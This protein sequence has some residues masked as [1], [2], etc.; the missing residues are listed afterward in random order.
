MSEQKT[1]PSEA[2]PGRAK[3][4]QTACG[5][6]SFPTM[7]YTTAMRGCQVASLLGA[8]EENGIKLTEL[9]QMTGRSERV[10]RRMIQRKRKNGVLIL[11][12]NEN[13]YFLPGNIGEIRRFCRSMK[14][15]AREINTV[16]LAAER[17]LAEAK[18][19]TMMEGWK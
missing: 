1:R 4:G 12:D 13:G 7:N 10:V 5:G 11:A 17:A 14:H 3:A 18:G 8:G 9:V 6:T 2:T 19:Q 16:T 15:R